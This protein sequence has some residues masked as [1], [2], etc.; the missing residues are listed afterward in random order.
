MGVVADSKEL[1]DGGED[2]DVAHDEAG[3]GPGGELG[4]EVGDSPGEQQE[5]GD[6]HLWQEDVPAVRSV[7][8]TRQC[9]DYLPGK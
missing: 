1:L 4:C 9:W 2:E 3:A 7:E 6:D 5:R 8:D